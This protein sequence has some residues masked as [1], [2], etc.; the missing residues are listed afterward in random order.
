MK[1]DLYYGYEEN[2]FTFNVFRIIIKVT[3]SSYA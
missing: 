3:F 2:I 1:R